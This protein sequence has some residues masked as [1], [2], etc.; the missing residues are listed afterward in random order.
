[1]K[2][3]NKIALLILSL[4]VSASVTAAGNSLLSY[5][6]ELDGQR[7]LAATRQVI[8]KEMVTNVRMQSPFIWT[9]GIE[10]FGIDEISSDSIVRE[11]LKQRIFAR[12]SNQ[13]D[14]SDG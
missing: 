7:S 5:S 1:M 14:N 8:F 10:I 4:L 3:L 9:Q 11:Q 2:I 13:N 6:A 12:Q